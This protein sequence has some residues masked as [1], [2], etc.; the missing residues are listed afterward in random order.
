MLSLA[1]DLP[2]LDVASAYDSENPSFDSGRHTLL[3]CQGGGQKFFNCSASVGVTQPGGY[4]AGVLPLG[5]AV[6][7][8][9]DV[10]AAYL[11]HGRQADADLPAVGWPEMDAR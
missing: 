1:G 8:G 4:R 7:R 6:V 3:G 9:K 5:V 11:R 2:S 10:C